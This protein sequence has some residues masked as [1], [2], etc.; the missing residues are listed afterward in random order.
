MR[1]AIGDMI[2]NSYITRR[3]YE[4]GL[5][6]L[7]VVKRHTAMFRDAWMAAT[8]R[9]EYLKKRRQRPDFDESRMRGAF[10]Y[11]DEYIDSLRAQYKGKIVIKKSVLDTIQLTDTDFYAVRPGVPYPNPVPPFPMLTMDSEL[12]KL[13]YS[14]K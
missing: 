4:D 7:D 3:A 5:D 10:T 13:C 9:E 8:H 11:T 12:E 6:K 2:V 14:S 1:L